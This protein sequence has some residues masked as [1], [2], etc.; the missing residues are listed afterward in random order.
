V[1]EPEDWDVEVRGGAKDSLSSNTELG[2]AVRGA[3]DELENLA[4]LDRAN[5]QQAVELLESFGIKMKGPP[6]AE[7]GEDGSEYFY[8]DETEGGEEGG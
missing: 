3:C 5:M 6:P 4:S 8:P 7:P 1:E 2:R